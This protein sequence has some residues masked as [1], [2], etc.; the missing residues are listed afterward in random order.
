[1]DETEE[2]DVEV[3]E[4]E[5]PLPDIII[6][7]KDSSISGGAAPTIASP[8][9]AAPTIAAPTIASPTIASPTI[10]AITTEPL[11]IDEYK[12]SVITEGSSK[13]SFSDSDTLVDVLGVKTTIVSPKDEQNLEALEKARSLTKIDEYDDDEDEDESERLMIGDNINLDITDINDL[14]RSSVNLKEPVLDFEVL[15]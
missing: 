6:K 2:Q 15:T 7:S 13:L 11:I 4:V 12:K 1:M 9:I 14:G 8:T 3:K 5:E 10:A